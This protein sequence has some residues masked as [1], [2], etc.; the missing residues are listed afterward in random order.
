MVRFITGHQ[1]WG[2]EFGFS[3]QKIISFSVCVQAVPEAGRLRAALRRIVETACGEGSRI[4]FGGALS[5]G[6]TV[7]LATAVEHEKST[8][9]AA[10]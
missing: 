5:E 4:V 3:R 9:E 10:A 8:T 7:A 1:P 2:R 6:L